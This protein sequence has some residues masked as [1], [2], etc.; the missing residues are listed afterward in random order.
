M[1]V[2]V[3]GGAGFIGSH[4]LDACLAAGHHVAVVDNLSTGRRAHLNP[5]A[6]FYEIDVRDP[7]LDGLFAA[8]KPEVVSHQ[9]ARVNVREAFE[10][11]LGYADVNVL[12]SLNVLECCRRHDTRKV[13]YAST[14]GVYGDPQDL[15]ITEEHPVNPLDPYAASKHHVEHYLALYAANFD[16][17][18]TVLRYA[19]IYGPRQDPYG[20]GGVVAIFARRMVD[21][22]QPVINGSGDQERDFVYVADV[23]RAN[24]RALDR[25]DGGTYNLGWGVGTTINQLY[26]DLAARA[27]YAAPPVHGPARVGEIFRSVLDGGRARSELD[28]QPLVQLD[29]GLAETVAYFR[30]TPLS[31]NHGRGG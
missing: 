12:G 8:E 7:Q 13:V 14:C 26:A 4:V 1:R 21:G 28:W 27:G 18:F 30:Q 29:A 5:G 11:P 16:L 25:G 19:N 2:L 17:A 3:T 31:R 9:A 24:L 10:Q 15:P 6:R 20:E 22:E 23:A